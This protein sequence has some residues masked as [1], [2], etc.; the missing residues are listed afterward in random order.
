MDYELTQEQKDFRKDFRAFLEKE[1]VP[2]ASQVDAQADFSYENHRRLAEWGFSGLPFPEKYGGSQK[3]ILTCAIAWEELAWACPSTF[4]SCGISLLMTGIA[5]NFWGSEDQKKKYLA[6]LI[7]G[8]IIGAFALSEPHCG[9]D[10]AAL[11]TEAKKRGETYVL[12]G[13]K[14]FI[15]NGPIA[16]IVAL[17]AL[18][19]P[20][21]PPDQKMS[22]FIVEKGT[23]GFSA[24]PPWKSWEPG[25]HLSPSFILKRLPSRRIN[26][27][28]PKG[29]A[30]SAL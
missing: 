10:I 14:A 24:G 3:P 17:F 9:S 30:G 2:G 26:Y 6:R 8:E 12:N 18:T 7:K 16:D 25:A 19:N 28:E 15:T 4:L 5:L 23:A 20:E 22:A 13:T 27:W 11:K 21:A 1:I 29:K